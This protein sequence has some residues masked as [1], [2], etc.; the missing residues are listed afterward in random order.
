M[1]YPTW[2]KVSFC[3]IS[4]N[5]VGKVTLEPET[6]FRCQRLP[7]KKYYSEDSKNAICTDVVLHNSNA[8]E[9]FQ[10]IVQMT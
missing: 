6:G 1:E 5:E 9:I 2:Y 3:R 10:E 8:L 7:L 4:S